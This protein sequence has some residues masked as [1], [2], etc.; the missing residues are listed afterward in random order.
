[1]N[2]DILKTIMICVDVFV[3]LSVVGVFHLVKIGQVT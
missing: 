3:L 2:N 1:M